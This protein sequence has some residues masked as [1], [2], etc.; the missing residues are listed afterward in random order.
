MQTEICEGARKAGHLRPTTEA[1]I[2][3]AKKSKENKKTCITDEAELLRTPFLEHTTYSPVPGQ[4]VL[5][6]RK[7]APDS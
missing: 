3:R 2:I 6:P 4:L 1:R 5:T 7:A